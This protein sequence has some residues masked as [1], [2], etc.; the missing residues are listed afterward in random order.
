MDISSLVKKKMRYICNTEKHII[1]YISYVTDR[2][3][4]AASLGVSDWRSSQSWSLFFKR[5]YENVSSPLACRVNIHRVRLLHTSTPRCERF[6]AVYVTCGLGL[7]E[8]AIFGDYP[9]LITDNTVEIIQTRGLVVFH[10]INKNKQK[11]QC[12]SGLECD[13]SGQATF[14]SFR[15]C[16]LYVAPFIQL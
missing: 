2:H 12:W 15:S 14:S 4:N 6:P 11:R 10:S 9:E 16:L 7:W 8:I 5:G 1:I 13:S 3:R